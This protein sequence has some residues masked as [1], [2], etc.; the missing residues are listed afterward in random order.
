VVFVQ[1]RVQT[2]LWPADGLIS[3]ATRIGP[4]HAL[5]SASLPLLFP[6]VSLRRRL[7]VDG[8]LRLSVPLSPALRLGAGRVIVVSVKRAD[9]RRTFAPGEEPAYATAPF[10]IGKTLDALFL[11]HTEADIGRLRQ[12]NA[13]LAAGTRVYG[14]SFIQALNGGAPFER[15]PLR[16]VREIHVK[17][18]QDLGS[19]AA[20]HTRSPAFLSRNHGVAG[21]L[22][23]ELAER[24]SKY[25]ADLASYLL[26]DGDFAAQLIALGH[27]DAKAMRDEWLRFFTD[28]PLDEVEA[29]QLEADRSAGAP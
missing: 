29:A 7:F 18:S 26:F 16:H 1:Q 4:K 17:P 22:L 11:D 21:R 9:R 6:A 23:R 24:E 19:L 27:A 5:A 3:V 10:L 25:E 2:A 8:G 13:L 14:S 15:Q 20:E 28:E 12:V